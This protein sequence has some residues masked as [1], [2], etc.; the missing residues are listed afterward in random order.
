VV[1][2]IAVNSANRSWQT[3]LNQ[4]F[5][6]QS[7]DTLTLAIESQQKITDPAVKASVAQA[8]A[9]FANGAARHRGGRP[10]HDAGAPGGG[11]A[12]RLRHT[13]VAAMIGLRVG[14]DYA[15]FIVTRFRQELRGFRGDQGFVPR[16]STAQRT[17]RGRACGRRAGDAMRTAG[18]AVLTASTTV[19][20]GM[21]GLLVLR[22]PLLNGVAIAAAVTVAMTVIAWL[23][24]LPTLLGFTGTRPARTSR[25]NTFLEGKVSVS[26]LRWAAWI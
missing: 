17:A 15:L 21:L 19:V 16:A 12:Y 14:V 6:R 24:L 9:P 1:D 18:R 8:L 25:M 2:A 13:I 4:H 11:R 3:L 10:V 23:T 7:A 5:A 20:I 22:Q 26:M